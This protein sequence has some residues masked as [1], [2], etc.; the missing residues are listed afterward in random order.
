MS[1]KTK[2]LIK[3]ATLE[4]ESVVTK[5]VSQC[6]FFIN[7]SLIG[8]RQL[9]N[10]K[11]LAFRNYRTFW[12]CFLQLSLRSFNGLSFLVLMILTKC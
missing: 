7:F 10:N 8:Y 1:I 11:M 9:N 6:F 12:P 5:L 4:K 3:R 2:F